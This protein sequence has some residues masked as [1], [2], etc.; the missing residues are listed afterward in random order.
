MI[1]QRSGS[2]W[3]FTIACDDGPPHH[4]AATFPTEVM[5]SSWQHLISSGLPSLES[6]SGWTAQDWGRHMPTPKKLSQHFP[7]LPIKKRKPQLVG[8]LT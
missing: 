7:G 8:A 2:R 4:E 6:R 5:Q 1:V 3:T